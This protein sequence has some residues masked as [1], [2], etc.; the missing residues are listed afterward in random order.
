MTESPRNLRSCRA[1]LAGCPGERRRCPVTTTP[2]GI[3]RPPG[4]Q[5]RLAAGGWRVDPAQSHASFAASVV[6]RP[7]RGRLPLAGEVL[8]TEP[9]EDSTAR[10]AARASAVSTGS[11][12]LDRLL[13]GPG[14][15]DAA[16]FP[17]ISFRSGRLARV[18]AGWRAV[19]R[20]QV[21]NTGYD[22]ACQ[23]DPDL[24]GT[25]PGDPPRI[26]IAS[27]WVIDSGWV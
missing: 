19:G 2:P 22:L 6:G 25:R 11:A 10:L 7:V 26:I 16:A 5:P 27:S 24:P 15:L 3:G 18:P 14:F 21:K 9:I 17:E 8:I 4:G 20:L 1:E 23:L 12:V 13:T